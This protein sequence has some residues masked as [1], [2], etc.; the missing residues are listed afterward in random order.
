MANTWSW[1][2]KG[3]KDKH[4]IIVFI[5]NGLLLWSVIWFQLQFVLGLRIEE[6]N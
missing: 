4:D 6:I 2:E 3:L 5:N 1:R